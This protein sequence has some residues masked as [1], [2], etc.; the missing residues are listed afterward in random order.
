MTQLKFDGKPAAAAQDALEPWTR[1]LYDDPTR[2]LLF[3]GELAPIERVEPS[4]RS[5]KAPV[6]RVRITHIEIPSAD[7]EGYIREALRA[8]YVQRTASG[9]F[10]EDEQLELAPDTLRMLGGQ[11]HA[12]GY[13][14]M[15]TTLRR[16][17]DY[18]HR[19]T[20]GAEL[21]VAEMRHEVDLIAK[22]LQAELSVVETTEANQDY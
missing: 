18:C 8:L 9:K 16:W 22:G 14:R 1:P 5:E 21:T 20:Y 2:Q 6:V 10:D 19:L 7:Q 4:P 3:V 17:A 12:V 13:A 15:K 11:L